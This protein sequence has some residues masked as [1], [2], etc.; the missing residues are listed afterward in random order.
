MINNM[1]V[2]AELFIQDDRGFWFLQQY[3]PQFDVQ[4]NE[5]TPALS[6]VETKTSD[7]AQSIMPAAITPVAATRR[8]GVAKST[9]KRLRSEERLEIRREQSKVSSQL[10]RQR[11][12]AKFAQLEVAN[13]ILTKEN[14]RL[15]AENEIL[16]QQLR[17][18]STHST[19]ETA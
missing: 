19:T 18:I 8:Q 17:P 7:V 16:K 15:R 5:S 3:Q 2:N 13:A 4:F 11:Q 12:R 6:V 10:Y 14:M 1:N 9:G